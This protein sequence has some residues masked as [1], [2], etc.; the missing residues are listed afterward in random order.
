[1]LERQSPVVQQCHNDFRKVKKYAWGL[2]GAAAN[3]LLYSGLPQHARNK[4]HFA[5]FRISYTAEK[6]FL[7]S[8]C[9]FFVL[10]R[11]I[12]RIMLESVLSHWT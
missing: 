5:L 2:M 4:T 11:K 3:F 1:M 8:F 10:I 6:V 7:F 9:F 12:H